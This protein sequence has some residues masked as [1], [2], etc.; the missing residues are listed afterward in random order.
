VHT[1]SGLLG[2]VLFFGI[3]GAGKVL[4]GSAQLLHLIA[5]NSSEQQL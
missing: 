2:G 1:P 3:F 5:A 4:D